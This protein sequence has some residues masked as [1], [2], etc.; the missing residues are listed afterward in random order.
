[1][2]DEP[3][4]IDYKKVAE[5]SVKAKCSKEFDCYKQCEKR[6]TGPDGQ[7][8]KGKH[9]TGFAIEYWQCID[10]HAAPLYFKKL[11]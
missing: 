1:M 8:I 10:H 6:I 2:S 7:Y 11:T 5:E 4:F 3:E 9:C